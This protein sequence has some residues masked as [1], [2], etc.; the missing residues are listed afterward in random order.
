[1][2]EAEQPKH[3]Q[4]L[5]SLVAWLLNPRGASATGGMWLPSQ[6]PWLH[7]VREA[8]LR[9]HHLPWHV[10]VLFP[11]RARTW[12]PRLTGCTNAPHN[13]LL[14]LAWGS[15]QPSAAGGGLERL[16]DMECLGGGRDKAQRDSF[17]QA[18]KAAEL[19]PIDV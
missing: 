15:N 5:G 3:T 13:T 18:G 16:R 17:C 1:M 12:F 2:G 10:L 9:D 19:N 4:D 8:L 11:V 7:N 6:R 14:L